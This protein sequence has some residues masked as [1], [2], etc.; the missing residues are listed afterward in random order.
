MA[1]SPP[2]VPPL[3]GDCASPA[4]EAFPTSPLLIPI[5]AALDTSKPLP[6]LQSKVNID[7]N[8]ILMSNRPPIIEHEL[9][10][11]P[12]HPSRSPE[13]TVRAR[14][15]IVPVRVIGH[16]KRRSMSVGDADLKKATNPTLAVVSPPTSAPAKCSEDS[17]GWGSTIRGILSD[18]KGELSQ[19]DQDPVPTNTLDLQVSS[20]QPQRPRMRSAEPSASTATQSGTGRAASSPRPMLKPNPTIVAHAPDTDGVSVG[21]ERVGLPEAIGLLSSPSP[22]L[23]TGGATRASH[24]QRPFPSSGIRP[25]GPR[26]VSNTHTPLEARDRLMVHHRPT[27]FSSEPSLVPA[28]ANTVSPSRSALSQQDL[29]AGPSQQLRR[30]PSNSMG[31]TDPEEIEVRGKECAKRAWDEDEEFLAKEKIA[32]WL[33]RM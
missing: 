11:R 19:L 6:P 2:P 10:P 17:M 25:L 5:R 12:S 28:N 15:A 32:E 23:Y 21:Q 7:D 3:P 8:G 22:S 27:A 9:S 1:Q 16:G 30:L 4:S 18:F 14:D 26:S 33:G 20:A 24:S 13:M 31:P 29:T